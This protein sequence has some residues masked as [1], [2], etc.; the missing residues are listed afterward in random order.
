MC[1]I[2]LIHF[3]FLFIFISLVTFFGI[4]TFAPTFWLEEF[5]EGRELLSSYY[6]D[7][8]DILV[9]NAGAL[10]WKNVL[11]TPM[12][13]YDLINEI[14]S[15]ATFAFAKACLP[16]MLKQ[17]YGH[18]ITMSPPID[19]NVMKGRVAYFIS[20]YG[21]TMVAHGLGDEVRGSGV[22]V[23]ALWPRTLV[24]SYATINHEMGSRS[25]WRKATI[26]SDAVMEIVQEDPTTFTANALIDEVYLRSKGVSDFTKYRCDPNVEP[27]VITHGD[28]VFEA[29]IPPRNKS[30]L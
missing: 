3:H 15:R 2:I 14:N 25:S 5:E 22:A 13:R 4:F 29:G 30:N 24:E 1:P 17:H 20:K 18:I 9:C 19:L 26:I 23:N 27:I 11:D 7:R 21:M 28:F 6:T 10:W 16:Y 8:I 12:K